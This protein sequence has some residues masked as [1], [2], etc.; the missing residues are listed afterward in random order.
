MNLDN[1]NTQTIDSNSTDSNS[2][3]INNNDKNNNI[4]DIIINKTDSASFYNYNTPLRPQSPDI[5]II[6]DLVNKELAVNSE[7]LNENINSQET[8]N[9]KR[10][11][12]YIIN[13]DLSVN[14]VLNNETEE[15]LKF[16]LLPSTSTSQINNESESSSSKLNTVDKINKLKAKS[17]LYE[18]FTN[19][20]NKSVSS[21]NKNPLYI[22]TSTIS[23]NEE[24]SNTYSEDSQNNYYKNIYKQNNLHENLPN[25]S[26]SSIPNLKQNQNNITPTLSSSS[27]SSSL[28]LIFNTS[29][30][31]S[32]LGLIITPTESDSGSDT[33]GSLPIKRNTLNLDLINRDE[34][35]SSSSSLSSSSSNQSI[36]NNR[37]FQKNIKEKVKEEELDIET[38]KF[39]NS[40]LYKSSLLI[41]EKLLEI[42]DIK[43]SEI[44]RVS[45]NKSNQSQSTKY[46]GGV[47]IN[48]NIHL[49]SK[50]LDDPLFL[51]ISKLVP[52]KD[53][54]EGYDSYTIYDFDNIFFRTMIKNAYEFKR[55]EFILDYFDNSPKTWYN[56][57][58]TEEVRKVLLEVIEE[59]YNLKLESQ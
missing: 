32:N 42:K 36:S 20:P 8:Q 53:F 9:N 54:V 44:F 52:G 40:E 55:E 56:L 27:S 15:K 49:N 51:R 48:G 22:I 7:S 38:F 16:S 31:D 1:Q 47:D 6:R 4:I 39:D 14:P 35:S 10:P 34:G 37:Q 23:E 21:L 33:E 17:N 13:Q 58:N 50:I 41:K 26:S 19:N 5:I 30:I 46:I 3:S 18:F 2:I 29:S 24:N 12:S 25:S 43:M 57:N 11:S 28:S 59:K 45:E